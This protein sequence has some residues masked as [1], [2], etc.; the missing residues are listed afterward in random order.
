VNRYGFIAW[1]VL[2]SITL[3]VAL[4]YWIAATERLAEWKRVIVNAALLAWYGYVVPA[5]DAVADAYGH[6][7][8]ETATPPEVRAKL[9]TKQQLELAHKRLEALTDLVRAMA[10]QLNH[11]T[12][13]MRRWSIEHPE[14]FA[15]ERR[16][17]FK[18]K[19]AAAKAAGQSTT[20]VD[21]EESA[22]ETPP[23]IIVPDRKLVVVGR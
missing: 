8:D 15:I 17:H 22:E 16:A 21:A 13:T 20:D 11:N 2:T 12:V 10:K 14:L 1:L 6:A 9:S 4:G 3:L 19:R 7:G 18:A 23:Q 5:A